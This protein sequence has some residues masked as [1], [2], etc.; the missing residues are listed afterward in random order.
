[1][2]ICAVWGVGAQG[3]N[4]SRRALIGESRGIA[5]PFR[6]D[7]ISPLFGLLRPLVICFSLGKAG[8]VDLL[9]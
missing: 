6:A 7:C 3:E 8:A 9:S 1:L 2:A 4:V 5:D